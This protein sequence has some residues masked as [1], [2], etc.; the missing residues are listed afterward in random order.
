MT[1][2][3]LAGVDAFYRAKVADGRMA[4]IVYAVAHRGAVIHTSAIGYA[5]REAGT[6]LAPDSV[7]RLY[8]M[9]KPLT[10]VALMI[11]HEE[12]RFTLDDP[13]SDY[14]PEFADPRVLRAVDAAPADTVPA[15]RPITIRDVLRHTAGL[16]LGMGMG[17]TGEQLLAREVMYDP[18]E[19]LADQMIKVARTPLSWQPG[20]N[21][22][23]SLAPDL[24]ARL[25]E[26]LSGQ[27][28]DAFLHQRI[29]D[30][31]GMTDTA[32]APRPD[33]VRRLARLYRLK[34]DTLAA[35]SPDDLPPLPFDL[36]WPAALANLNDTS[37]SYVRGSFGLYSTAGDYLRFARMLLNGGGLDGVRI[38]APETVTLMSTDQLGDIPMSWDVQGLGFGLGFAVIKEPA[39][40]LSGGTAGTFYWDGA[41]G[42]VFWVDPERD[43]AVVA[44]VQ[45]LLVPGVDPHALD[46]ELHHQIYPALFG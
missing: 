16:G 25:V 12:G 14:L 33:M 13:V 41:A 3:P 7:F 8:S 2:A 5:D 20:T 32:F 42:T 36:V 22:A 18:T 28:F 19:T 4:G 46:A 43:L 31:L 24:Q 6:P 15:E 23:Y 40:T 34:G 45:H 27:S 38:L 26:V 17:G 29:L 21:W 39:R 44:L 37:L 35:W 1:T 10:A 30:P 9:T 11:L